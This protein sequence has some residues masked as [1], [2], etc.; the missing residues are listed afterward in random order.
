[1]GAFEGGRSGWE[2]AM[3]AT[4]PPTELRLEAL[5]PPR[6]DDFEYQEEDLRVPKPAEVRRFLF[7]LREIMVPVQPGRPAAHD[8][9]RDT[10]ADEGG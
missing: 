2:Q 10:A 8:P 3:R 9:E 5:Q 7:G 1:M 6:P 4:H